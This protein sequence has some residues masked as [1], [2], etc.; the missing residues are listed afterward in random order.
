MRFI[1]EP[2]PRGCA[3]MTQ[4]SS[5]SQIVGVLFI[6]TSPIPLAFFAIDFYPWA[7]PGFPLFPSL[8]QIFLLYSFIFMI[9]LGLFLTKKMKWSKEAAILFVIV[10]IL[11][12]FSSL[13]L[14]ATDPYYYSS[15]WIESLIWM[16]ANFL[17]LG[18]LLSDYPLHSPSPNESFIS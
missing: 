15:T 12:C 11:I 9:P 7:F 18:V 5:P 8:D 14:F 1:I 16:M 4:T 6:I 2:K 13:W 17:F 10:S 3:F